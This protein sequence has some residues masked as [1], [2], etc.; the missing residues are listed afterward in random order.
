M[1]ETI[2]QFLKTRLIG[3]VIL[4]AMGS[5]AAVL[6]INLGRWLAAR[7]SGRFRK[8]VAHRKAAHH[9]EN[10]SEGY[11][12]GFAHTSSYHQVV[13][14]GRY[15]IRIILGSAGVLALLTAF[16]ISIAF[17][18]KDAWW[19]L[20]LVFGA[21]LVIPLRAIFSSLRYF[22]WMQSQLYD[23][24]KIQERAVTHSKESL[25]PERKQ[26]RRPLTKKRSRRQG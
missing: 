8:Y 26:T 6:A 15:L 14:V 18:L 1:L 4:G 11:L 25:M 10:F 24:K 5:I 16:H 22:R 17:T 12:A 7:L 21:L 13:L 3:L 19:F 20:M 2:D 23:A 9:V